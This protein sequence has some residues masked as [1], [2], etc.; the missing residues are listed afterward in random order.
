MDWSNISVQQYQDLHRLSLDENVDEMD[1]IVRA[2]CIM[3][4]KTETQVDDMSVSEFN[5]LAKSCNFLFTNEIPGKPQRTIRIGTRKYTIQYDPTKLTQRQYVEILSFGTKP[6]ENMH[7]IMASL[8]Q[9]V[10]WG[11]KQKNNVK[12]HPKVAMDMLNARV[13]DVYQTCVFFCKV[14]S[15]LI[16]NIRGYLIREMMQKG[17]TKEAA[18]QLVTSSQ[19]AMDGFFQHTK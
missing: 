8:V 6:I 16:K 12:D 19:N 17:A 14:Y 13:I 15:S 10:K 11:F 4:N 18:E 1:R 7:L 3:Y 5:N 9:P 2:I